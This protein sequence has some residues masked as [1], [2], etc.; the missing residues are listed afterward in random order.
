MSYPKG[1][2]IA[3]GGAEDKGQNDEEQSKDLNFFKEGILKTIVDVAA[4][5]ETPKIEL[6]TTASSIP[7]EVGRSYKKAFR[8][9]GDIEIGHLKITS[10]EEAESKKT[11]ERLENCNCILFSGGD[12]LRFD[13]R[14]GL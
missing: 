1:I 5:K 11:M 10:R 8:K 3:I 13:R 9:L 4:K 7:D 2:L 14:S 12:Q 6:I